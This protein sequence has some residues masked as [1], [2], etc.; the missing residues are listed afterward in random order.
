MNALQIRLTKSHILCAATATLILAGLVLAED[1]SYGVVSE[2]AEPADVLAED[3]SIPL[4]S[5]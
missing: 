2:Q 1:E 4:L 3:E 5:P